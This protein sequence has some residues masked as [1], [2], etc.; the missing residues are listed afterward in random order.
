MAYSVNKVQL[1]GN[2]GK[3]PEFKSVGQANTSLVTFSIATTSVFKDKDGKKQT[4]WHNCQACGKV[5]DII[6][7][8]VVK[9]SKIWVEG[10]IKYEKYEN[11]N[12]N[13]VQ[14]T[15]IVVNDFVLLDPKGQRETSEYDQTGP[16][17]DPPPKA[18][19]DQ[20][21]RKNDEDLP[22]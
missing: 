13:M 20:S 5:A 7:Q 12:G 21:H 10:V 3:D 17:S 15:K 8:Y 22:F 19:P 1:L 2:V 11:K 4:D 9:G 6:N 18:A 16:H 14:A